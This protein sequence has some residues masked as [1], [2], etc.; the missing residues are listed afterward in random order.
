MN[1]LLR[2]KA[3]PSRIPA[4]APHVIERVVEMTLHEPSGEETH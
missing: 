4:L 2:G 1:G 3:R